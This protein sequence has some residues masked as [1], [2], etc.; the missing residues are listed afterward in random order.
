MTNHDDSPV[1]TTLSA[2]HVTSSL[3]FVDVASLVTRDEAESV[4]ILIR[5]T[6]ERVLTACKTK[7]TECGVN[8]PLN[9]FSGGT[10]FYLEFYVWLD[11]FIDIRMRQ[12][13][14]SQSLYYS[15][16]HMSF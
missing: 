9:P 5:T 2:P 8:V 12:K 10:H 16:P 15:N 11:D 6:R 14:N 7:R 4:S 13:I 3:D 1:R